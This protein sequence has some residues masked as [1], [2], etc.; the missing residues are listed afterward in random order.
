MGDVERRILRGEVRATA[1]RRLE[2]YAAVFNVRSQDLGGFVEE[3]KPGAFQKALRRSDVRALFNH[4]PDH[5]LGR[6]RNGTLRLA[7]DSRGLYFEIDLPRNSFAESLL[8]SVRR[9]DIDG[10]SFSFTVAEGGDRWH[11]EGGLRVRT[12]HEIGELFDVGPVTF[13]AYEATVVS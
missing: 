13:P 1:G 4:N 7:D 12:V 2:G 10:A 3:I 6:M 8:E 11:D 9:G 5:V